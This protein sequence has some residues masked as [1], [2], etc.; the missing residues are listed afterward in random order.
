MY[1]SQNLTHAQIELRNKKIMRYMTMAV[2]FSL[3]FL[4]LMVP[5]AHAAGLNKAQSA[6][7][8]FQKHSTAKAKP[9]LVL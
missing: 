3:G 9:L 2:M 8:K 6:M 7:Q 1:L 5:E 4:L